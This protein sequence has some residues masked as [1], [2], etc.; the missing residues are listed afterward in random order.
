M[1]A[2]SRRRPEGQ[3]DQQLFKKVLDAQGLGKEGI[4]IDQLAKILLDPTYN[5]LDR[6]HAANAYAKVKARQLIRNIREENERVSAWVNLSIF[7]E[8]LPEGSGEASEEDRDE[9]QIVEIDVYKERKELPLKEHDAYL[10]GR[11]EE[12]ENVKQIVQD[13]I[14]YRNRVGMKKKWPLF[15]DPWETDVQDA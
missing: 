13:E 9:K 10:K 4:T 7:K 15:P 6:K 1:S 2:K 14:E 11:V 12:V 5:L 3:V 8:V